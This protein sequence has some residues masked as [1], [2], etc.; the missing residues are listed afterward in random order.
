MI[1]RIY[2]LVKKHSN[3][4]ILELKCYAL[5]LKHLLF[6][7]QLN[8]KQIMYVENLIS[9]NN[10]TKLYLN[11]DGCY[12]I[13]ID[14]RMIFFGQTDEIMV[15]TSSYKSNILLRFY[16]YN[17]SIEYSVNI[18]NSRIDLIN[19]FDSYTDLPYLDSVPISMEKLEYADSLRMNSV[20]IKEPVL[21]FS[22]LYI[23][24]EPFESSIY[25]SKSNL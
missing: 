8:V 6:L 11:I 14:G 20:N 19:K 9:T 18:E 4:A 2:K 10:L 13:K 23:H 12:K 17:K 15:P 16:G 7:K 5:L 3:A 24:K 22:P 21:L 1:L 25:L